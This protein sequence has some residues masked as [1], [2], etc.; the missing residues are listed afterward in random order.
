MLVPVQC[1]YLALEGLARLMDTIDRVRAQANPGL[2]I[3]GLL[4]TMYDGRTM[5]SH[6][7]ATEVRRHYPFVS[8]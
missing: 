2:S 5:L 4:L 3:L 8:V 6:Q 7:V 1:E